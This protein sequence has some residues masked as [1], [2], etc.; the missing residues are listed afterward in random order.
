MPFRV[1]ADF[2]CPFC[3]ALDQ[4]LDALGLED[5]WTW[6][7]I[8]HAPEV[9]WSQ[10]SP[11]EHAE[12]ASEVFTVRHR[13]P[14]VAIRLPASRP[15]SRRA[16][17]LYTAVQASQPELAPALRR[18]IYT[19]LWVENRDINDPDV[20]TSIADRLGCRVAP[21]AAAERALDTAQERWERGPFDRR[22][23]A[24]EAPDGRT[25]L[26]LSAPADLGAFFDGQQP[27]ARGSGVCVFLPRPVVLLL[28][29]PSSAWTLISE[30]TETCDIRV[31]ATLDQALQQL[32][33]IPPDLVLVLL[34]AEVPDLARLV[35]D[36]ME[37]TGG[38]APVLAVDTRWSVERARHALRCGVD[39]VIDAAL[40]VDLQAGRL[41]DRLAVR[42]KLVRLRRLARVDTLTGLAGR[43]EF[44]RALELEW[45]RGIRSKLP[46]S[47]VMLDIDF[48]KRFNDLH[49]HLEGDACLRAV[50][51]ALAESA[52]RA[53]DLMCRFGG[54]E[55]VAVLPDTNAE[56][57]AVVAERCLQA[58]RDLGIA[59]G[60]GHPI[61][62][63]SA[64]AATAVPAGDGVLGTLL[65]RADR[66]LFEAKRGGRDQV[67][68]G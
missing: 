68:S 2:N 8:E 58:V 31:A 7:P 63:V 32:G 42:R 18:A 46:L 30:F 41:T 33:D 55:F 25:L 20:L 24:I 3:Y 26:G 1:F 13:A 50:A 39:E 53:S 56:A 16:N 4:R 29:P 59:H 44:N 36:A 28:G 51:N 45:Q 27:L 9:S 38:D 35:D 52:G 12:L 67:V 37:A 10:C 64:G 57:A 65:D 17:L 22:L 47:L 6:E 5:G 66:A 48:F 23:P 21:D 34:Q 43:R 11:D 15:R 40:P 19:A 54:E 60:G 61:V 49:G 14:E 62:T